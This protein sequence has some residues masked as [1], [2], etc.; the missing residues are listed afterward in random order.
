MT[1]RGCH[2][3]GRAE[4]ARRRWAVC[5]VSV[6]AQVQ[7]RIHVDQIDNCSELRLTCSEALKCTVDDIVT[8]TH[9]TRVLL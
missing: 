7:D 5:G 4:R 6:E 3:A 2:R 1:G 8:C 9:T